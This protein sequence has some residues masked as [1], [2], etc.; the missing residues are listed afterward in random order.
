MR[1]KR[2]ATRNESSARARQAVIF[3]VAAALT[4]GIVE[5]QERGMCIT[6]EVPAAFVTP[7]R[8]T[9]EP[10]ALKLCVERIHSPVSVLHKVY[11]HGHVIGLLLSRS[12]HSEGTV[13]RPYV[14][15]RR[16]GRGD[17]L[18]VGYALPDGDRMRTHLL[19]CGEEAPANLCDAR[20]PGATIDDGFILAAARVNRE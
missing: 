14:Q 5:A 17:W 10:G 16:N 8:V 12:G 7:D 13:E 2:M 3:L 1:G 19:A 9:H 18:L 11:V 15:F 6:A 4:G 20:Q